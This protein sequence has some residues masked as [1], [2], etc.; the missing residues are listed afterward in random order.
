MLGTFVLQAPLQQHKMLA[1]LAI[2][3]PSEAVGSSPVLWGG[4]AHRQGLQAAAHA[5]LGTF[6]PLPQSCPKLVQRVD[7]ALSA[8]QCQ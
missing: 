5:R 1:P 7:S 8:L 2:F 3:A 4:L 6:A